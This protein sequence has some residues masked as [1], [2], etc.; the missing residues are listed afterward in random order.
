MSDPGE[1]L[2]PL[3]AS[4][5]NPIVV[6]D[7]CRKGD[8]GSQALLVQISR[9][10]FVQWKCTKCGGLRTLEEYDFRR[11]PEL[12]FACGN[13]RQPLSRGRDHYSNYVFACP[14]CGLTVRLADVV[15]DAS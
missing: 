1:K 5:E 4:K 7:L 14:S 8:C 3:T 15:P 13:C 9:G 2:P 6:R 10:G 12:S 11:L